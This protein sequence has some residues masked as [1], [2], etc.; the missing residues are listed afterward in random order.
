MFDLKIL[1]YRISLE[2]KK[3]LLF[4]RISLFPV[5]NIFNFNFMINLIILVIKYYIRYV[6]RHIKILFINC[7]EYHFFY[8]YS[9]LILM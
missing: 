1:N 8:H 4:L 2:L 5:L 3:I 6:T 9:L 7:Y